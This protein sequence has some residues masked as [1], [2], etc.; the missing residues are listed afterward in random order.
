MKVRI[1]SKIVAGQMPASPRQ[2]DG[3]IQVLW[4]LLALQECLLYIPEAGLCSN[5]QF[6]GIFVCF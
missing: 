2:P 4:K 1:P 3:F 5:W 6:L